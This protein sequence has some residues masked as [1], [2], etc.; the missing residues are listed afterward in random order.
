[1]NG[2]GPF[3]PGRIVGGGVVI[4][5]AFENQHAVFTDTDG[6][7]FEEFPPDIVKGNGNPGANKDLIVC[8]F[9]VTFEDETGT[10]TFTGTVTAFVVGR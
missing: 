2:N 1:M 8:D 6:N 10:G 3:T 7:V 4:P 5:V 9:E